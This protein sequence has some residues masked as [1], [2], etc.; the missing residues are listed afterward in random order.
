MVAAS[1]LV[2]R[3][4]SLA[5]QRRLLEQN[6]ALS[7]TAVVAASEAQTKNAHIHIQSIVQSSLEL[8][9]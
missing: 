4:G 5:A 1:H 6:R 2:A 7:L 3:K 9:V 8:F